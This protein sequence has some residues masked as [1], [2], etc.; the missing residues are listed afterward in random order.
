MAEVDAGD[1]TVNACLL[2][3]PAVETGDDVLVHMGFVVDVL[4]RQTASEA[5]SFRSEL[6]GPPAGAS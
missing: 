4:D 2:Y 5:R 1:R 3:H 6:S